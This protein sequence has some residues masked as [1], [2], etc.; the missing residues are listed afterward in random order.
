MTL[1]R[2]VSFFWDPRCRF[3]RRRHRAIWDCAHARTTFPQR[4]R[5]GRAG[6]EYVVCLK[7]GREM[8][9]DWARMKQEGEIR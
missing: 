9:Y 6:S 5:N 7:C 3:P 1:A 2:L 8:S 4:P